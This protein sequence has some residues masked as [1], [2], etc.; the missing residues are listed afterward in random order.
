MQAQKLT[1][2]I[3]LR[4]TSI[5]QFNCDPE[6]KRNNQDR[7]LT[8]FLIPNTTNTTNE[9]KSIYV[10][11]W[12]KIYE[13]NNACLKQVFLTQRQERSWLVSSGKKLW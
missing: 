4:K 13:Q 11:P 8:P 10:S 2:E 3:T 5:Y 9:N 7:Q 6:R 12:K 1:I